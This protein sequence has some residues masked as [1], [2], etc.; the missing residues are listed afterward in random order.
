MTL[1][2][3]IQFIIVGFYSGRKLKGSM[4]KTKTTYPINKNKGS[5]GA[6]RIWG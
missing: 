2:G 1:N 4:E 5:K 3:G 6:V